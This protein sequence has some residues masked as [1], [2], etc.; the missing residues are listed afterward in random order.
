[1]F[2]EDELLPLSGVADVVFCERRA[3]LHHVEGLWEDNVATIEGAFL[4]ERTDRPRT[5]VHGDVRIVRALRLRSLT[6]GLAGVADVVEFH[7]WSDSAPVRPGSRASRAQGVALPGARGRWVPFPVEYKR[8]RIRHERAFKVQLCAQAMCLEEMLGATVPAGALFYGKSQR[9]MD[10]AF[11][12]ALRAQTQA[13]AKRFHEIVRSGLTP[14]ARYYYK[15][16]KE[17]SLVDLCLPASAGTG[18]S[19]RTYLKRALEEPSHS[20]GADL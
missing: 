20:D 16:C 12:D 3:A 19:A 4:H 6:L 1:V 18:R 17:C 14:P 13:A 15:K 8:G 10:V 9:R 11:D 2:S 7:R 5:E